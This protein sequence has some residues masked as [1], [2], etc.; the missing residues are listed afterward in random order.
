MQLAPTASV[1][2]QVL[3][4]PI[5]TAVE[6][7]TTMDE[8]FNVTLPAFE[9]VT[10][11]LTLLEPMVCEPKF[12]E[13]GFAVTLG[14]GD[15]VVPVKLTVA[16]PFAAF[17]FRFRL[18]ENAPGALASACTVTVQLPPTGMAVCVLQLPPNV[19]SPALAPVTEIALK[20]NAAC[21][22]LLTVSVCTG[23]AT[24]ATSAP[25]LTLVADTPMLA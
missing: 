11:W 23:D 19:N 14:A 16:L 12:T 1:A 10:V 7:L 22:L 18:A 15:D 20:F 25:K 5:L 2:P 21:P 13:A 9:R 4:A 3:D 8:K 6:P 17:E 24:L